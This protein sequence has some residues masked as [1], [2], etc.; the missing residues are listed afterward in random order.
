M[1]VVPILKAKETS[2][3]LG[4]PNACSED[5]TGIPAAVMMAKAADT[6]VLVVGTDLNWAAEGM[7]LFPF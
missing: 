5:Q 4:V 7:V 2:T 1:H 3:M 6:V